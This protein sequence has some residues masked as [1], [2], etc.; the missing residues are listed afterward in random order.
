MRGFMF[1][2]LD[3]E[4]T[5]LYPYKGHEIISFAGTKLDKDLKE[6]DRLHINIWPTDARLMDSKAIKINKFSLEEWAKRDAVSPQNAAPI[7]ADFLEGC[8]PVAHNWPF[9]RGFLLKLLNDHTPKRK[10]LRR[11]ID[12]ITLASAALL[13]KGYKSVSM[14]SI[15]RIMGWPEQT[16]D[17][18]DDTLM[19]V[20]LFRLCYPMGVRSVIKMQIALYRA[21]LALYINPL[22]GQ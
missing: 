6:I 17:A 21:K 8:I 13:P 16:H 7:I 10:I 14:A 18:L 3:T 12:T 22:S 11:G 19:C 20:Q 4:T 15:A 9:D 2:V 5:G 1:V